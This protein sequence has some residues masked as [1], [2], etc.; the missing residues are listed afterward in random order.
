MFTISPPLPCSPF[1]SF[2]PFLSLSPCR[3]QSCARRVS[4]YLGSTCLPSKFALSIAHPSPTPV[5]APRSRRR[6][7]R[8]QLQAVC[9]EFTPAGWVPHTASPPARCSPTLE[10]HHFSP[11]R[12]FFC[13]VLHCTL[14]RF[15]GSWGLSY[16][17]STVRTHTH[18]YSHAAG[19]TLTQ[20]HIVLSA[21]PAKQCGLP[22]G[23]ES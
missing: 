23:N 15:T 17:F 1:P 19:Y 16:L 14:S 5:R 7:P 6:G 18:T 21:K 22:G 2:I 12:V 8:M 9:H 4:V 13:R 20:K 10:K 11:E 3:P